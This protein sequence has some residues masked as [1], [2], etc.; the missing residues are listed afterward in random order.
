MEIGRE[1][2]C[3]DLERSARFARRKKGLDRV[4]ACRRDALLIT[5]IMPLITNIG[6]VPEADINSS[7]HKVYH[8]D[9]EMS[10]ETSH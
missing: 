3:K 1:A 10:C 4:L 8:Q 2:L 7:H 5:I 6:P 9:A